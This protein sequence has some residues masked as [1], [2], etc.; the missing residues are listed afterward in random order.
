MNCTTKYRHL[1]IVERE[2]I[3]GLLKE[4]FSQSYIAKRIGFDKSTI[5]REIDRG[6]RLIEVEIK[7][8]KKYL[9]L[10]ESELVYDAK[11]AQS[12]ADENSLESC[13]R[14]KLFKNTD[15]INFIENLI[16]SDKR[17]YSPDVA[18]ALAR[19]AGYETVST[20]TLYNWIEWGLLKIK[21][22]D[23][24]LKVRRSPRTKIKEQKKKL[25]RSIDERPKEVEKREEFGHWEGDSI[26]GAEQKG[27]IITLLE[28]KQRI[29]L[30]FKFDKMRA[31]NMVTVLKILKKR[32]GQKFKQIFKTITFDNGSEFSY[33]DDMSKFSEIFYA[34]AYSSWERGSNEN[35]NGIVRRFIPKGTDITVLNQADI[36][37]INHCI[38]TMPRKILGYKTPLEMFRLETDKLE[39]PS[40][41]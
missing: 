33:N 3:Q 5:S 25:G 19:E 22:M 2:I 8:T 39:K 31:E 1:T 13:K 35:F 23:L 37:R 26:V 32:Y 12:L 21:P 27:Q 17:R 40:V 24:L 41:A 29:G 6:S 9:P 34:H 4:K 16:L 20:K 14:F 38:N 30:M 28:R 36:D 11:Y 15:Y 10:T 18:N 7:T